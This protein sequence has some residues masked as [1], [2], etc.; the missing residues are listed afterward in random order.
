MAATDTPAS[1]ETGVE[2]ALVVSTSDGELHQKSE[3]YVQ[4]IIGL[5]STADLFLQATAY[6]MQLNPLP[7]DAQRLQL[8]RLDT[9]WTMSDP[10]PHTECALDGGSSK[11][12]FPVLRFGEK[13]DIS[14]AQTMGKLSLC[15]RLA[16]KHRFFQKSIY[17]DA[18][19]DEYRV[20]AAE[21]AAPPKN[22]LAWLRS[23]PL[24]LTHAKL[25]FTK[26]GKTVTLD[27]LRQR[28]VTALEADRD[29]YEESG[30]FSRLRG[31]VQR[32]KTIGELISCFLD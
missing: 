9:Y 25:T 4:A 16:L 14:A 5:L 21:D 28:I 10:P 20:I 1:A 15:T 29:F 12:T 30:T 7:D 32:S 13:G 6:R 19:G 17:V 11:L 3:E 27:D 24:P 2:N 22:L 18:A 23:L 31:R 26:T 8:E